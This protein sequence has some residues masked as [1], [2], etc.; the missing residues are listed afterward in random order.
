MAN[1]VA[2]TQ[3]A[4]VEILRGL[5]LSQPGKLLRF[6]R[7]GGTPNQRRMA[8]AAALHDKSLREE[9]VPAA[10]HLIEIEELWGP[11][12]PEPLAPDAHGYMYAMWWVGCIAAGLGGS[13]LQEISRRAAVLLG[14]TLRLCDW[15]VDPSGKIALP[16]ARA[17]QLE[18]MARRGWEQVWAETRRRQG[19]ANAVLRGTGGSPR[20]KPDADT[21]AAWLRQILDGPMGPGLLAG[22]LALDAPL[23]PTMRLPITLWRWDGGTL[24]IFDDPA[25]ETL[26]R[27]QLKPKQKPEPGDFE[28]WRAETIRQF[29]ARGSKASSRTGEPEPVADWIRVEWARKGKARAV[30]V[31]KNWTVAAPDAPAGAKM[32]R[33]PG[34]GAAAPADQKPGMPPAS[35]IP[36]ADK[37]LTLARDLLA[38]LERA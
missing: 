34:H 38:D 23:P 37:V 5:P 30:D 3:G 11:S 27:A 2:T 22:P 16:G 18:H 6:I 1:D 10:F 31:G 9:A 12:G 4:C 29:F 15:G 24:G 25:T 32:V 28:K 26:F 35:A 7:G 14:R 19:V 20:K 36:S 17:P 13:V 33:I 8:V 21:P